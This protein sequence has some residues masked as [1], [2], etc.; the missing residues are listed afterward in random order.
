MNEVSSRSHSILMVYVT[1]ITNEGTPITGKLSLVDLAGKLNISTKAYLR[2]AMSWRGCKRNQNISL[3]EIAN[4]HISSRSQNTH[5]LPH[6]LL[7]HPKDSLGGNSKTMMIV[8][9]CPTE[10]TA[11][12]TIFALQVLNLLF[13]VLSHFS[14]QLG[15]GVF[16]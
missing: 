7:T 6:R 16:S 13:A 9:V 4:S 10:L 11:D 5:K 3:I 8:T 2:S 12:E 15:H 1:T 14:S